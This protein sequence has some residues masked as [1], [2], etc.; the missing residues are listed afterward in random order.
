MMGRADV[1]SLRHLHLEAVKEM[2]MLGT[3]REPAVE[4]IAPGP[5]GVSKMQVEV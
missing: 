2:D 5:L 1:C 4:M 3:A